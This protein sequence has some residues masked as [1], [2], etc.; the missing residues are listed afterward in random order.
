M[1]EA[2]VLFTMSSFLKDVAVFLLCRRFLI[3]LS[4]RTVV[5]CMLLYVC[6]VF[7]SDETRVFFSVNE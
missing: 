7:L 3:L 2:D 4:F 1:L 5:V 6:F